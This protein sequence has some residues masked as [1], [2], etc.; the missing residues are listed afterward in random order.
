MTAAAAAATKLPT[1]D[2]LDLAARKTATRRLLIRELCTADGYCEDG[3]I[4]RESDL[5]SEQLLFVVVLFDGERVA[6]RR[7]ILTTKAALREIELDAFRTSQGGKAPPHSTI[8][9]WIGDA[10]IG[11][12][13][14]TSKNWLAVS[15]AT[16]EGW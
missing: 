12:L 11:R 2:T 3:A 10:E 13:V 4:V 1:L 7:V 9:M 5:S 14:S 15:G 8:D 16:C 6:R